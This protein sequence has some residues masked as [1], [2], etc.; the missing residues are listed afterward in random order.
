MSPTTTVPPI[1]CGDTDGDGEITATDALFALFA[2]IG[3]EE[4][5]HDVCD[6]NGDGLLTATDA[7]LILNVAVRADLVLSCAE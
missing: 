5:G 7:L 4:C 2:A 6:A 3:F 1:K